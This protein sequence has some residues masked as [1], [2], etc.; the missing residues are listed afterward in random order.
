MINQLTAIGEKLAL[1][2]LKMGATLQ[3]LFYGR[4]EH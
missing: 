2:G 1:A 3:S 4:Q